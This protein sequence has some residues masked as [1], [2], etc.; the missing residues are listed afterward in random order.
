MVNG[1][2]GGDS[3][4]W[5]WGWHTHTATYKTGNSQGPTAQ[6]REPYSALGNDADG[7]RA[8]KSWYMYNSLTLLYGKTNTTLWSNYKNHP[9]KILK[10]NQ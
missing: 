2:G 6:H 9:I 7:K 3:K 1:G 8:Q 4:W 5:D 10:I